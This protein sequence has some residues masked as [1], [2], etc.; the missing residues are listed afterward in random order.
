MCAGRFSTCLLHGLDSHSE[1]FTLLQELKSHN[2]ALSITQA[3]LE[4][5]TTI[6]I[7]L[8]IP[9]TYKLGWKEPL[10]LCP[11]YFGDPPGLLPCS[12][13]FSGPPAASLLPQHSSFPLA[14]G[15]FCACGWSLCQS[16]PPAANAC[17][18][19]PLSAQV[20]YV[21]SFFIS[22]LLPFQCLN[23]LTWK[24]YLLRILVPWQ[25][26][27]E[28][29]HPVQCMSQPPSVTTYVVK[30]RVTKMRKA[31]DPPCRMESGGPFGRQEY[32]LMHSVVQPITIII[33]PLLTRVHKLSVNL[34]L[35]S[36]FFGARAMCWLD[37]WG[38]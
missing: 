30:G 31:L 15:S 16:S 13:G 4:T 14:Q 6:A 3:L 26:H 1:A 7:Y 10:P 24:L 23:F 5:P 37:R 27:M 11:A 38:L 12:M 2:T 34:F 33:V 32:T 20:F 21:L 36:C 28:Q 29:H 17:F 19:F 22:S 9:E 25:R 35:S 18:S 8:I